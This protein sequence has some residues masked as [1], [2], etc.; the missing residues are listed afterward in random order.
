MSERVE[1]LEID[2]TDVQTEAQETGQTI[3]DLRAEV[4]ELRSTFE[5]TEIGTEE[6]GKALTDLTKKQQ[7][8]TNV[9]KS[10]IAAQKGSYNDLVNQ[11]A[12]LKMQ[13]RST[14]DEAERAQLGDQIYTINARLKE[15]DSEIG[16]FQ[17]N[18]GN[19]RMELKQLKEEMLSLEE[20]TEE[21]TAACAR[22]A[23]ISQKMQ[24]VNEFVAA[25]AQD[26][27]DHLANATGV[28]SG[29]VGVFQ[30]VQA[31]LNLIGVESE[32]VGKVLVTMQ[33]LMAITQGLT[34]IE[35]AIDKYKRLN[36]TIK[37]LTIV[38]NLFGIAKTK[39]ATATAADTTATVANTT[40]TVA[41]T[42]ATT[43][44]TTATW[45]FN[46]AL[47][48]N[49]LGAILIAA[50]AVVT[51][52]VSLTSWLGTAGDTA[53]EAAASNDKF[54]E[55]LEDQNAAIEY[56]IQMLE[57]QG[58]TRLEAMRES[59]G[60][61]KKLY[62][63]AYNQYIKIFN[64][65]KDSSRWFGLANP[66]S[67]EEQEEIN[68]AYDTYV[69][70]VEKY[71]DRVRDINLEATR[72]QTAARKKAEDDALKAQQD[73]SRKR[74]QQAEEEAKRVKDL[75]ENYNKAMTKLYDELY[76]FGLDDHSKERKQII[77]GINEELRAQKAAYKEGAISYEE[78]NAFY[79]AL[80]TKLNG[81]L[82]ELELKHQRNEI[83]LVKESL[84]EKTKLYKDNRDRI[85][86]TLVATEKSV[87]LAFERTPVGATAKYKVEAE[88]YM[89]QRLKETYTEQLRLIEA[90]DAKERE[91]IQEQITILEQRQAS[92]GLLQE[93]EKLLYQL[94]EQYSLVGGEAIG[95]SE[96]LND[97]TE[98]LVH[99][100]IEKT[101]ADM[102]GYKDAFN[103]LKETFSELNDIG[104][105]FSDEWTN[106]FDSIITGIDT[107]CTSLRD[108]DSVLK[109]NA[110]ETEKAAA[111][112]KGY[113]QMAA[114]GLAVASNLMGALADE[115]DKTTEEGF[116]RAKKFQIAQAVMS[117]LA[118]VASAW[119]SAM[120]LGPI[121]GPIAGALL[122]AMMLTMG[123]LQIAN[124]KK[125]KFDGGGGDLGGTNAIPSLSAV[126][127][128]GN[129]VQTTTTIEGASVESTATDTR[130]YV[131]ESDITSAQ[132]NVKTT[133]EEATF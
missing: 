11:M 37:G 22:A 95:L 71:N 87:E 111:K 82:Q 69:A 3:K 116:E 53:E 96:K 16:N 132:N 52:L 12:L 75:R 110:S 74:I 121:A 105:Y 93:E 65:A 23:E 67:D 5:N 123:G 107:A 41:Q 6:F 125:Q 59:L 92:I 15:M 17:R 57:A 49:P 97:V 26:M 128:I 118:G 25:S 85:I 2:L 76:E 55:S 34:A 117:T 66:I 91:A 18:V 61:Q 94:R 14:A 7:E 19:Y 31:S 101:I 72:E 47:A 21:Y 68:R 60:D 50:T 79:V 119:A 56:N 103:V 13:W 131:L 32:N 89:L 78:M 45:S 46:A 77:D 98:K 24:D 51:A 90:Q 48:A 28:A 124:I 88:E 108:M 133:V 27:G 102:E 42:G 63:D 64:N 35:G 130:V 86:R 43:A 104:G 39:T 127:A 73:A 113:G 120:Q 106:V 100:G 20:G 122:S 1:I 10:G 58:K 8:L 115:Q 33:N 30:T 129:P 83:Q 4:R 112:W 54:T 81:K 40:A 84:D 62:E 9:T 126:N 99:I 38:Q 70:Q 80:R 114:A 36:E 44:A 29:M 109:S